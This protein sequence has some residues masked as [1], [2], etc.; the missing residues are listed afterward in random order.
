MFILFA[1]VLFPSLTWANLQKKT[2]KTKTK[3]FLLTVVFLASYQNM[4]IDVA[5]FCQ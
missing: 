5:S 2:Q 4:M 1:L 3:T